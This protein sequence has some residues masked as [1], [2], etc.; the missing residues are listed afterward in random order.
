MVNLISVETVVLN[1]VCISLVLN[2]HSVNVLI[3]KVAISQYLHL[4]LN[5][6]LTIWT[7]STHF[8]GYCTQW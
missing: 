3:N 7:Y 2:Q 4:F 5:A 6:H 8:S 1:V